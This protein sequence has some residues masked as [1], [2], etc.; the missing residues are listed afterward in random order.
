MQNQ[1]YRNYAD[2]NPEYLSAFNPEYFSAL[3]VGDSEKLIQQLQDLYLS[4]QGLPDN[5][6]VAAFETQIEEDFETSNRS[7]VL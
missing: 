6:I 1:Y 5:Q 3:D 4:L 7:L 2:S